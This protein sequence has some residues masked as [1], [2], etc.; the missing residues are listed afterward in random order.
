MEPLFDLPVAPPPPRSFS[1]LLR[2]QKSCHSASGQQT[3][4][5]EETDFEL[6]KQR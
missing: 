5:R 2:R 4:E 3:V 1:C 6:K